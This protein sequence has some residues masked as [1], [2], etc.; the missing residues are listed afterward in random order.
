LTLLLFMMTA[1]IW[2]YLSHGLRHLRHE[3]SAAY[4]R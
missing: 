2:C 3:H 4:F 1:T